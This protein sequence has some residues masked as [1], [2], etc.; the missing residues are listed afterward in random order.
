MACNVNLLNR[1]TGEDTGGYFVYLGYSTTS[2]IPANSNND[3]CFGITTP[4]TAGD[5][6]DP[7]T[8]TPANDIGLT[9]HTAI[10]GSPSP[11]FEGVTPGFYGFM[12]IV[13]DTDNNGQIDGTEC[14]DVECFEIEVIASPADMVATNLDPVC[15]ADLP[16]T[17]LDVTAQLVPYIAGGTWTVTGASG[18]N[19]TDP[20]NV[21]IPDTVNAGTIFFNYDIDAS[22]LT[23]VHTADPNC[24][25]CSATYNIS[26]VITAQTT[27][28]TGTSIAVCN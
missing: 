15:E 6:N 3:N 23:S 2:Q 13:G 28:G 16:I 19:I 9:A 20:T 27:A 14:G 8:A 24:D 22:D 5:P 4:L 21:T 18:I 11:S 12:Y 10:T 7:Y 25:D 26:L 1:L 17:N